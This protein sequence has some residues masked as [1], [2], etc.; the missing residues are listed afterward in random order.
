MTAEGTPVL[1]ARGLT[2]TF[3]ARRGGRVGQV[4]AM[5]A[6]DISLYP[7]KILALVG[8]SGSGKSTTAKVLAL[9]ERP[10]SGTILLDGEPVN[11]PAA[12][13]YRRAVQRYRRAVQMVFQDPFASLNPAHTVAYHLS[14]PIQLHRHPTTKGQVKDLSV[15]LLE[16]VNLRPAEAFLPKFPHEL[17]GGQRQRVAIALGLAVGPKVLL[18]DEPVSML[19]VSIRLGVL[20]LLRDLALGHRLA[21]LYITHDIASARYFADTIA[22]MY[23]GSIVERGPA[24]EI[25][26]HPA[27]PYTK[28][29]LAAAP[30]AG[31]DRGATRSLPVRATA[32]GGGAPVTTGCRFAPRCPHAV[33]RCTSER[34]PEFTTGAARSAAC[35]LL[36]G[37]AGDRADT[38]ARW[39]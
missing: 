37:S 30:R 26:E 31:R 18:A 38:T 33:P 2:K 15:D 21:V 28:L 35:F 19:D 8:Q 25:V 13:R 39:Q 29:L 34:P 9:L 1:E 36:M 7:G 11:L 12:I 24:Q 14:R 3:V 23:E 4:L 5:S 10:D 32:A 20:N 17:S 27:H 16:Q 6:V 22:V